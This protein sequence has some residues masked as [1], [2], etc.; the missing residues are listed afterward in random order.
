M[1]FYIFNVLNPDDVLLGEKPLLEERGPYSYR[2]IRE[3]WN[4]TSVKGGDSM[5]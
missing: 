1:K 2:E 5:E 3:K 4:H